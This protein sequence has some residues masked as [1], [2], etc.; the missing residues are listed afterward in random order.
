MPDPDQH[1]INPED[2]AA[3]LLV[4]QR[5]ADDPAIIQGDK[6]LK[7]LIAKIHRTGKKEERRAGRQ[8]RQAD[9]HAV[10]QATVIVRRGLPQL[11]PVAIP[12]VGEASVGVLHRAVHCY[13]CKQPFTMVHFFYHLLCPDCASFCYAKRF[14]RAD[15]SGRIALVTGGRIK[16]GYQTALR[17]LRDGA[18]VI[19]TT[20]FPADA[21]RRFSTERDAARWHE[22]LSIHGLDL[23]NLSA[24]ES[25][26]RHLKDAEPY[27]DILIN[28]AAQTVKRPLAFYDHLLAAEAAALPSN[29]EPV[30][31]EARANY[32]EAPQIPP[33]SALTEPSAAQ[34]V[35]S[36][37]AWFPPG[38]YDPDGQQIDK[39]PINSW[40]LPLGG[41]SAVELV[42]T[43]LVNAVAPFLLCSQLGT[44]LR[45]SPHARRFI[46]NVSAMEGQ[47]A[48]ASK[49][50]RHPH[51]NMAKAALNMLTRTSAAGCAKDGVFMNSV[52][53][54]WVTDEN[55][56]ERR[57]RYQE[58]TGFV[59][60][61]DV[62]D[63]MA[64]IYDPIARGIN[65]AEGPLFGQ[66]LKDFLPCPW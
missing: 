7:S 28:N 40:S 30:L 5:I 26:A 3:C 21:T 34:P 27:L 54:G 12:P 22:R 33:G 50:E 49:T 58:T 35:A 10:R 55:P 16:I 13:R 53:T 8:S 2:R 63:G 15:L 4:L 64:R 44:L 45:G 29:Q 19:V 37:A 66:F 18:R 32:P 42:E 59:T 36:L 38:L 1:E 23:R 43:Q 39:R 52:D 9:D 24:V 48:R 31:L 56:A 6:R 60:P 25:F 65:E 20:R 51:T 47:F 62:T 41:I 14:Q 17:L 57:T 11:S 46:V 61:L